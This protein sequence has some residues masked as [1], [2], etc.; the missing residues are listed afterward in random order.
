MFIIYKFII[1]FVL[2]KCFNIIT[3]NLKF[4]S[5]VYN[6]LNTQVYVNYSHKFKVVIYIVNNKVI[7]KNAIN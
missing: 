6:Y 1:L 4:T 7:Q 5:K 3:S 2:K